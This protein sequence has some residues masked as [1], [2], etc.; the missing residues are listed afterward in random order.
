[1]SAYLSS[2]DAIAA[3]AT[4][5]FASVTN[6]RFGPLYSYLTRAIWSSGVQYSDAQLQAERLLSN[7]AAGLVI[8]EL[9][10]A[11]NQASL[12]ARYPDSPDMR[13]A[14]HYRYSIDTAVLHAVQ[15]RQ[16]TGA[17]VGI[18]RGYEYQSCEHNGW[19][20]SIGY[21]ICQQIRDFLTDDLERRDCPDEDSRFW[22]DYKRN[23]W[24]TATKACTPVQ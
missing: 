3:L 4:Y 15:G 12:E 11:E 10:L 8:F 24:P 6:K 7:R 14:S 13:E 22:A 16:P 18:L 5:W 9:L 17:L 1:M 21:A 2:Q 23:Q 19:K 20:R